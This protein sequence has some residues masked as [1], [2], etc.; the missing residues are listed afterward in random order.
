MEG[1]CFSPLPTGGLPSRPAPLTRRSFLGRC[2]TGRDT[3]GRIT[4]HF[5]KGSYRWNWPSDDKKISAKIAPHMSAADR[6]RLTSGSPR[7][8]RLAGPA[9]DAFF[10]GALPHWRR[11]EGPKA[12]TLW[13]KVYAGNR[14][15]GDRKKTPKSAPNSCRP[16]AGNGRLRADLG[17][18]AE[19]AT[20]GNARGIVRTNTAGSRR[21]SCCVRTARR[22]CA[23]GC[24][25]RRFR[26][27][28]PSSGRRSCR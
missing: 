3:G 13:K 28:L 21:R 9:D 4:K 7:P 18:L 1:R 16:T 11:R 26:R 19:A 24:R 6:R 12:K 10:S 5:S 27:S 2:P 23:R 14:R 22:R 25:R 17:G 20:P 8:A 15:P